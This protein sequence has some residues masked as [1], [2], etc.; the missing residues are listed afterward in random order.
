MDN[1]NNNNIKSYNIKFTKQTE[2]AIHNAAAATVHKI[3]ATEEKG[4]IGFIASGIAGGAGGVGAKF[5]IITASAGS[6]FGLCAAIGALAGTGLYWK[7]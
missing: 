7:Y 1:N 3:N 2:Q 5:F 6:G 4:I